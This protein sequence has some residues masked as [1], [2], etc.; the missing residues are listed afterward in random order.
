MRLGR[1]AAGGLKVGRFGVYQ[2]DATLEDWLTAVN[3]A[4]GN[5][6]SGVTAYDTR[7][8]LSPARL[9]GY[10]RR[11]WIVW[12]REAQEECARISDFA[13]GLYSYEVAAIIGRSLRTGQRFLRWRGWRRQTEYG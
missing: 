11:R 6:W 1:N 9:M 5:G 10:K 12:A 3:A 7:R 13:Y 2:T 4:P 8:A